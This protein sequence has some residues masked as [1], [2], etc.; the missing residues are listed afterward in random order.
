MRAPAGNAP[1]L[2]QPRLFDLLPEINC[3]SCAS[4]RN[5]YGMAAQ[6]VVYRLLGV[7]EIRINGNYLNCFD[8]Y[9]DGVY[10]EIKSTKTKGGK[11]V[12]YDYRMRKDVA[13]GVPLRYLIVCHS[14]SGERDNVLQKMLDRQIEIVSIPACAVHALAL[15]QKLMAI[16]RVPVGPHEG[17]TRS[18][19]KEGYR[20]LPIAKVLSRSRFQRTQVPNSLGSGEV[21][22]NVYE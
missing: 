2:T 13:A 12:L 22:F 15:E 8:G 10:Y 16:N 7:T 21:W 17:Y 3:T 18:G 20:N 9:K 1:P 6:E 4:A 19:Y 5:A 14:I 11:V